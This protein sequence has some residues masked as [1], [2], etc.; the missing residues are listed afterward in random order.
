MQRTAWPGCRLLSLPGV[1]GALLLLAA[2]PV[3][4]LLPKHGSQVSSCLLSS[5]A[6]IEAWVSCT[7]SALWVLFI[8]QFRCLHRSGSFCCLGFSLWVTPCFKPHAG[9]SRESR[10]LIP[11][12]QILPNPSARVRRDGHPDG[13]SCSLGVNQHCPLNNPTLRWDLGHERRGNPL[14][15]LSAPLCVVLAAG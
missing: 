4:L 5:R 13:S 8:S 10:R 7:G 6:S 12:A 9:T 14:R 3:H 15:L 1:P 2:S 11:H